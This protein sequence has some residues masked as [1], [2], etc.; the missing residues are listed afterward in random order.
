MSIEYPRK[1]PP[2][3]PTNPLK[4]LCKFKL[5]DCKNIFC[6][7]FLFNIFQE[8]TPLLRYC[9]YWNIYMT[10]LDKWTT[11][12][13]VNWCYAHVQLVYLLCITDVRI[14]CGPYDDDHDDEDIVR[15]V[16]P[17]TI[18]FNFC[19]LSGEQCWIFWQGQTLYLISVC[20]EFNLFLFTI[21]VL[22]IR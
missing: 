1:F 5:L 22:L 6:C 10:S 13:F 7:C 16:W 14:W 15:S 17:L 21:I 9:Q 8:H 4:Q 12:T 11:C 20:S 19:A 18:L 3:C 2:S